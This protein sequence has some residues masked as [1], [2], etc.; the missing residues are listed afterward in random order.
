M[1]LCA[2]KL[3][4]FQ[5][6]CVIFFVWLGIVIFARSK[7]GSDYFYEWS[8]SL[9]SL[10]ILF[11]TAN[12][13]DV[14]IDAGWEF[15][16]FFCEFSTALCIVL[17][18]H[19]YQKE[20]FSSFKTYFSSA[21]KGC[22]QR[23]SHVLL[24]LFLLLGNFTLS[25]EQYP[26]GD[27]LWC[28][29]GTTSSSIAYLLP[30]EGM[31]CN[32]IC[33]HLWF[34]SYTAFGRFENAENFVRGNLLSLQ[35]PR[36]INIAVGWS[37]QDLDPL[38]ETKKFQPFFYV[39]GCFG[40]TS[41]FSRK[42]SPIFSWTSLKKL[43]LKIDGSCSSWVF[44]SSFFGSFELRKNLTVRSACRM[45]G[46]KKKETHSSETNLLMATRNPKAWSH[47][48][49]VKDLVPQLGSGISEPSTAG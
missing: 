28:L 34:S 15:V 35:D 8:N 6:L 14:M 27:S 5:A 32:L 48:L 18:K 11:T 12:F 36:S 4:L 41:Q 30:Q 49:D 37:L 13:P 44:F 25:A 29:Q 9:A 16:F 45:P 21:P 39:T 42:I 47:L 40:R 23:E 3:H 2:S 10:W 22:L 24:L 33:V 7:E 17:L 43:I 26:A 38:K 31:E 19:W 1:G 20:K 46:P